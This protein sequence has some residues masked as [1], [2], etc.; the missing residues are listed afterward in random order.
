MRTY[1]SS[2]SIFY[3]HQQM[4]T[5]QSGVPERYN[6]CILEC[7]QQ[8]LTSFF[9]QSQPPQGLVVMFVWSSI[10]SNYVR[11]LDT[12][13]LYGFSDAITRT[14]QTKKR[15]IPDRIA[16]SLD[17][18]RLSAHQR[19]RREIVA[20]KAFDSVSALPKL[21]MLSVVLATVGDDID[22]IKQ[23]VQGD[24]FSAQDVV[25]T[26]KSLISS[27]QQ[28]RDHIELL[29]NELEIGT[30]PT[31]L[32]KQLYLLNLVPAQ[33]FMDSSSTARSIAERRFYSSAK[34]LLIRD[35]VNETEVLEALDSSIRKITRTK[36][37]SCD[38]NG[39]CH[40]ETCRMRGSSREALMHKV[41]TLPY[42][43]S[44]ST[45]AVDKFKLQLRQQGLIRVRALDFDR[46]EIVW[47][48]FD[49]VKG[50]LCS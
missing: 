43:S 31:T 20:K 8:V 49:P 19:P 44:L 18:C 15:I 6:K 16:T 28:E 42:Q 29:L 41:V 9:S 40:N 1:I 7:E 3:T 5:A 17:L 27:P 11:F 36:N 4:L 2:I 13:V 34:S 39:F 26:A 45:S 10:N 23:I 33:R 25:D 48:K 21:S 35:P 46:A 32:S 37:L 30:G 50:K 38:E 14:W 12:G 47:N 22:S 24:M